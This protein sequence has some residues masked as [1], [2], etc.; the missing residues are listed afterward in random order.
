MMSV[1]GQLGYRTAILHLLGG[2]WRHLRDATRRALSLVL[3]YRSIPGSREVLDCEYKSG[4]WD[5]LRGPEELPRFSIVAGYC[6]HF[7]PN[8]AILEI[9]CGEGILQERTRCVKS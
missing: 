1:L 9:G 6:H 2:G 7:R 4:S 5:Y 3:P 8:S